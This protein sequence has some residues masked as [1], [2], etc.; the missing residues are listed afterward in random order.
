V[1]AL[2]KNDR[3]RWVPLPETV[4]ESLSRHLEHYPA[5]TVS[6]PSA[7]WGQLVAARP[8]VFTSPRRHALNRSTMD[9]HVWRPALAPLRSGS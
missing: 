8:L 7:P 1:F 4:A 9:L 2:P 6:L 3:D 5:V